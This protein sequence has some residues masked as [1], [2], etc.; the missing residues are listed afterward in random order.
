LDAVPDWKMDSE[1]LIRTPLD[2]LFAL[3]LIGD[4]MEEKRH[5]LMFKPQFAPLVKSGVKSRTIRPPRK[6][7]IQAGDLLDL[8]EW[9][10]RPYASKQNKLREET[11]TSLAEIYIAHPGHVRVNDRVLSHEEMQL[12]AARDG[13]R[14][15][16]EMAE[17]FMKEHGL[18]F[19]GDLIEWE[20]SA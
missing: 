19:V 16:E 13:F 8:R 11:C 2:Y 7:P 12:F 15:F 9:S 5:V 18:P 6:R 10:G 3:D 4:A 20:V 17:F 1:P 14:D